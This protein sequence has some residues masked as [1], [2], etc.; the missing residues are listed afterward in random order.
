MSTPVTLNGV[1]Y[2]IPATGES[3]WGSAVSSY[4][5]ALS[6]GVLSK[7]G[8]AFTLTADADFGASYGLKSIYYKSRGTVSTAGIVRLGNN[9]S[10]GWR[11]AAN[12]ADLQLK[13]NASDILEFGGNPIVTLALG[14][15]DTVLRMNSAGTAYGF[16]KLVNANID[17]AAAVAYSKLALTGSIVNADVSGSAAIAYSKLNLANSIVT[18]DIVNG[19]IVNDDISNTAQIA[20]SKLALNGSITALDMAGGDLTS[21]NL[22]PAAAISYAQLAGL[23]ASRAVVSDGSGVIT[24]SSVTSTEVGRLSGIGSAA[25]GISDTQVI[26]NKDID[27]GTA[28]NTRRITIPKAA[29]ATLAGLTR[30]QG[31]ILYDTDLNVVKYDDGSNLNTVGTASV[32]TSSTAGIVTTFTPTVLS[33]MKSVSSAGY[34]ILDNDG[35]STVYVS[36]G[37][38]DQTIVLPTAAD[39]A[40]RMIKIKKT[41]SGA[42]RVLVDGEGAETIDG[43]SVLRVPLQYDYVEVVSLG[44]S[45]SIVARSQTTPYASY[46]PTWGAGFG[47]VSN[48]SGK[49]CRL[50]HNIQV[51][52]SCTVGTIG[53]A[54][55]TISLPSGATVDSASLSLNNTSGNPGNKVGSYNNSE[56]IASAGGNIVTAPSTSTSLVYCSQYTGAATSHLTPATNG[57]QVTASSVTFAVEFMVPI[58][59]WKDA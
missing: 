23:T 34:T 21:A 57:N 33:S 17:A 13:V 4:L 9:E 48:S 11:N 44:A 10:V 49:W 56:A 36:T 27:G 16:A 20:Y 15:A 39:N 52:A 55:C 30:K 31:T 28:A 35:Y 18:G 14:A 42:G 3:N 6:T 47:T 53:A 22:D 43:F 54:V 32:A 8:G 58:S 7:A 19:T 40:G 38:S 12:G 45:W 37:A 59:E 51:F 41:D 46:T 24:V 29:T 26:T 1:S 2:S 25:V 5:I 50:G